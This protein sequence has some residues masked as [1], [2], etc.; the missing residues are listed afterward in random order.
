MG[1]PITGTIGTGQAYPPGYLGPDTLL[2]M[3]VDINAITADTVPPP[4]GSY[5]SNI[6]DAFE[7]APFSNGSLTDTVTAELRQLHSESFHTLS[8]FNNSVLERPVSYTF[9]PAN[10]PDPD[11]AFIF[12]LSELQLPRTASGYTFVAPGEWG[13]RRS[14]GELQLL[15]GEMLQQEAQLARAIADYD[16]LQ[17]SIY[18][19]MRLIIA[20]YEMDAEIRTQLLSIIATTISESNSERSNMITK[21]G[22]ELGAE[23]TGDLAEAA[24]ELAEAADDVEAGLSFSLGDLPGQ[25]IKGI[26]L[27]VAALIK[28]GFQGGAL[29]A[30]AAALQDA[31]DRDLGVLIS[32]LAIDAAERDFALREHLTELENLFGDEAIFRVEI[33]RER[34]ALRALGDRYRSL[35][36]EGFRLVEEQSAFNK[37]VAELTQR[38]RYQDMTFRVTRNDAL[39]KYRDAFDL[40]ARYAYLAAKAY[41]YETNLA[42]GAAGSAQ[43]ILTNI[44]RQRG[45][46][47]VTDEGPQLGKGGLAEQLAWMKTNYDHLKGQLG[48]NNPQNETGRFSLRHEHFRKRDSSNVEW[49]E[50]LASHEVEDLWDIPEFRRYC[51]PFA[52]EIDEFGDREAQPGLVIPFQTQIK[53]GENF[54]GEPLG[55]DD[56]AYDPSNFSTKIRS[57]GVWFETNEGNHGGIENILPETPRVYLV[58][59]GTDVMTVPDSTGLETRDWNVLDQR[60]PVPLPVLQSDLDD[61]AWKPLDS[62]DGLVAEPRR[63]SS[64]RAYHD[65]GNFDE[66]EMT[67]DSRLVGRSVW[68]RRW[69]LIIPGKMLNANAANGLRNFIYGPSGDPA[70]PNGVTDIKLFFQTYGYSGG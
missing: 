55:P 17:G 54:F 68:N 35:L 22:L 58:P 18:R 11:G 27:G 32:E 62:L 60:I 64:F 34:E 45:L 61:P 47:L 2:Y 33:M 4:L 70:T 31:I 12:R 50:L 42:P 3:Y 9:V 38:N 20:R 23:L 65:R 28:A 67:F 13:L 44:V 7:E 66:S 48:F 19:T 26:I 63:F 69:L 16:G 8:S 39:E 59:V 21:G 51:R 57:I 10:A 52:P 5:Q 30:E 43:G 53:A 37:R 24:G 56:H 41:D 1:R 46:G 25:A 6:S 40:A 36:E 49:A 15:I 29:A 14:T